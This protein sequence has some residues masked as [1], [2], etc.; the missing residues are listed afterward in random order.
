MGN[1]EAV[2][3]EKVVEPKETATEILARLA[4]EDRAEAMQVKRDAKAKLAAADERRKQQDADKLAKDQRIYANC[5]H[6]Q[7]NHKLGTKPPR[8]IGSLSLHTYGGPST[9]DTRRIRCNKCG[10]RWFP[11]DKR[12]TYFRNGE[13]VDNPTKMNWKDAFEFCMK[14]QTQGNKPSA[15]FI[16]I[17]PPKQRDNDVE[18]DE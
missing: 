15:G 1:T 13:Q 7:G 9:A 16:D 4:L 12:K 10:H 18:E 6:L 8:E 14:Y 11:G 2:V 3:V 17:A 5:D